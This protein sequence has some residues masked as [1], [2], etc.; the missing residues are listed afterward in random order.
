MRSK[1]EIRE[2]LLENCVDEYGNL[3]LSGLDFSEFDGDI[4][5][6]SMK[7]KNNLN[8]DSQDVGGF[9]LQNFQTVGN[10]IYQENQDEVEGLIIQDEYTNREKKLLIDKGNIKIYQYTKKLPKLT[11]KEICDELGIDDFEF[12]DE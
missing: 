6:N 1:E 10:N 8:Q 5:I 2:W 7:V 11:K 9:L 3:N 4:L 12:I